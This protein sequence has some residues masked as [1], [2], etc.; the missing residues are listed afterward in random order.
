MHDQY[1]TV[2]GICHII[3]K[4]IFSQNTVKA[5]RTGGLILIIVNH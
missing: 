2:S 4:R 1:A 3:E 5:S